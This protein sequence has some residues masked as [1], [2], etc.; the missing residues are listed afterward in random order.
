MLAIVCPGQGSQTPGFLAPWLE[1]PAFRSRLEALADVVGLDLV[2]HGTTSDAETIRDTAVAQPL[3]VAS[4]IAAGAALLPDGPSGVGVTAGHSVGEIT[5]AAFAGVLSDE[6]AMVFVRERGRGMAAAS[7]LTPTGMSAV[8]GGDPDEVAQALAKHGL[9]AANANGAG[10]TVA[11]GTLEQLAALAAEPPAKTRVIPLQ[12]AGAFHTSH[13]APAV[14]A[15]VEL[16]SG[17]TTAD[18]TVRLLSNAD[19]QPVD[20]GADAL[21]RLVRQ[22]SSPVR[23]DQCMQT[24]VDLGVTALIELPPAGTLVGLAK[25]AMPGV[26]TLAVK[27]PDDL[28]AAHDLIREHGDPATAPSPTSDDAQEV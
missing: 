13:M 10:Q 17:M 22:V 26:T 18:P 9:T 1:V 14:D 3:I 6:D 7:A 24:L 21:T 23:W 19:G 4:G 5:A 11:A 27:T 8:L 15:L 25:R 12:V 2:A 28:A 16:T 20:G